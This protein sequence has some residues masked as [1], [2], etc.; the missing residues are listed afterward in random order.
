M[1]DNK[2]LKTPVDPDVSDPV[3]EDTKP[4]T[5]EAEAAAEDT[6]EDSNSEKD[7][8]L[9]DFD[10]DND[11]DDDDEEDTESIDEEDEEFEDSESEDASKP[12]KPLIQKTII[13]SLVIVIISV[14]AALVIT[15]FFSND[16]TGTWRVYI[17]ENGYAATSDEVSVTE[18]DFYFTFSR[19]KNLTV[20]NG[21][22]TGKGTYEI[23]KNEE[24]QNVVKIDA[25]MPTS[26]G[27]EIINS[28]YTF[29]LDGTIFTGKT[30]NLERNITSYNGATYTE[31]LELKSETYKAPE[32]ER[33]EEFEKNEDILGEWKYNTNEYSNIY[34]F[35]D[36]GTFSFIQ[37]IQKS[38]TYMGMQMEDPGNTEPKI[39][40]FDL[41]G[42]YNVKDTKI[43]MDYFFFEQSSMD[44]EYKLDGD[45]LYINGIPFTR[46]G[47]ATIDEAQLYMSQ[48][49]QA[50]KQAQQQAQQQATQQTTQPATQ[51]Q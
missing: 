11:A 31:K 45:T 41:N 42:I 40:E 23:E 43:T 39:Y 12:K 36:D 4:L 35:N 24:G 13:I 22:L 47:S 48:Q 3:T 51:A 18:T 38:N 21:T 25:I 32:L 34:Q 7:Y 50:Q 29:T 49:Q 16:V 14:V 44:V 28:E 26:R 33:K 8:S 30:L 46:D 27:A 9:D 1:D 37:K 19:D 2:D 10:D 15:L 6:A 5:E 20:A 17:P